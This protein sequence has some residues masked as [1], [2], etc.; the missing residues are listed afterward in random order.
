LRT[1]PWYSAAERVYHNNLKCQ[2]A[3]G[4]NVDLRREGTGGKHSCPECERLNAPLSPHNG[5][6]D[7][8]TASRGR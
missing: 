6:G 7:A 3:L 8:G 1:V 5:V 4:M 2:A